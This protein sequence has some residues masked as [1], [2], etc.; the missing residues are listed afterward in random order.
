MLRAILRRRMRD[1]ISGCEH[2]SLFTMDLEIP[3]LEEQLRK[4]GFGESGYEVIELVG[5]EALTERL[6]SSKEASTLTRYS[7]LYNRDDNLFPSPNGNWVRYEDLMK[8]GE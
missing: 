7:V 6:P 2:E 1:A 4:G 5:M 8:K 3:E